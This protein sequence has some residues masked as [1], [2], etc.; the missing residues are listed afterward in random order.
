M[1]ARQNLPVP[2]REEAGMTSRVTTLL[3]DISAKWQTS[4][5]MLTGLVIGL[6]AG[7]I[8]S[9]LGGFQVR[10]STADA[11]TRAG[12]VEQQASFCAERARAAGPIAAPL[13]W[14]ERTELARRWATVPGGAAAGQDVMFAC[15]GKL[16]V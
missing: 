9:G 6:I 15:A 14:Q 16:S 1:G 12:I 2:S 10:S 8:I 5:P 13:G 7:P 4:K 11:A 3:N